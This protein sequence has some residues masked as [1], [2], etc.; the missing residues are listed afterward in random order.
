MANRIGGPSDIH[1]ASGLPP[2]PPRKTGSKFSEEVQRYLKMFKDVDGAEHK[3]VAPLT[4][5]SGAAVQPPIEGGSNSGLGFGSLD[6]V[7]RNDLVRQG[8]RANARRQATKIKAQED[9]IA[10]RLS[11]QELPLGQ[12]KLL[13]LL[14]KPT[15]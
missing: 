4:G 14:L 9:I 13:W 3:P 8:E 11:L 2:V 7:Q 12:A 15:V 5:G 6:V 10:S 1:R